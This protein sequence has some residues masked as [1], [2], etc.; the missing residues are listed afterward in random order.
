M[1]SAGRRKYSIKSFCLEF[2]K[3]D[4]IYGIPLLKKLGLVYT[5]S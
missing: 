1:I 2:E 5:M 4:V 3:Q